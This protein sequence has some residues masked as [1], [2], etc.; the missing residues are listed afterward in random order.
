[1][2]KRLDWLLIVI[3]LA[4]ATNIART[5]TTNLLVGADTTLHEA[6]P[7]NNFGGG[8]TFTTGGGITTGARSRA[9]LKFDIAG[10]IP[11]NA[12]INS[13]SLQLTVVSTSMSAPVNSDFSLYRT[14]NDWGEGAGSDFLQGS[15]AQEGEATWNHRFAAATAWTTAGGDYAVSASATTHI[16][17]NANYMFTSAS[18][19]DDVQFW[20]TNS[21]ANFGWTL[22]SQNEVAA[23]TIRRFG[24]K[25]HPTE[26]VLT[27]EFTLPTP[28]A[29]L[30]TNVALAGNAIEFE[31]DVAAGT[32]Y[33]V[34]YAGDA[35]SSS[36]DVLTNVPSLGAPATIAVSDPLTTTNRYYRVRT[37]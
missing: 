15:P 4:S 1:M 30:I 3:I 5:D 26:P 19:A 23:G 18:F 12:V 32:T 27:V 28:T 9:L 8:N 7:D 37:P 10:A 35:T 14:L 6:F 13:V 17:G 20:L 16:M 34:E 31:F 36:W 11:A 22:R 2:T 21:A 33:T 29:I 24:G 25:G